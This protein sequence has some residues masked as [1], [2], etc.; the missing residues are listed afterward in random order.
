MQ[1]SEVI[2]VTVPQILAAFVYVLAITPPLNSG[3]FLVASAHALFLV[4]ILGM[5]I[6]Y[7]A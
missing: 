6:S 1:S 7:K 3:Q 5:P 2:E 4:L